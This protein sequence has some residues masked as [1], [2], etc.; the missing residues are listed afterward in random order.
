[1]ELTF[2]VQYYHQN[3]VE[4]YYTHFTIYMYILLL[5]TYLR[6]DT[7]PCENLEK[8][9]GVIIESVRI[10]LLLCHEVDFT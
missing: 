6:R 8:I 3:L 9:V 5:K 10:T 4:T 7:P 1:M 2:R